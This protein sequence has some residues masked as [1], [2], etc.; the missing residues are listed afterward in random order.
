MTK[1]VSRLTEVR[2]LP[3]DNKILKLYSRGE[4]ISSAMVKGDGYRKIITLDD[5][6][7]ITKVAEKIK[8]Q[9][10]T[11]GIPTKEEAMALRA[12]IGI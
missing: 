12:I 6:L 9:P 7:N 3:H 10:R 11:S 2:I 5:N 1:N 8:G 4:K